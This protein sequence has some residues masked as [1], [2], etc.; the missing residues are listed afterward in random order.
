MVMFRRRGFHDSLK[1]ATL[2][3]ETQIKGS[4]DGD[5]SSHVSAAFSRGDIRLEEGDLITGTIDISNERVYMVPPIQDSNRMDEKK[6]LHCRKGLGRFSTKVW[7]LYRNLTK[8]WLIS[9]GLK[10]EIL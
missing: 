8:V 6:A 9:C 3:E 5:A 7:S 4:L 1:L 10:F 2:P